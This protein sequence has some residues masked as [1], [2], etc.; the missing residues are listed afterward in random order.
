V[1][2]PSRVGVPVSPEKTYTAVAVLLE[3]VPS[4][5]VQYAGRNASSRPSP[6]R[7]SKTVSSGVAM[8]SKGSGGS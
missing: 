5:I 3:A 4:W 1:I 8:R 7:S 6:S 2:V